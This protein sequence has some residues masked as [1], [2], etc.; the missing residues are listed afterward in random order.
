MR[1]PKPIDVA[2]AFMYCVLAFCFGSLFG[3]WLPL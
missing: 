3:V 2:D 1:Y